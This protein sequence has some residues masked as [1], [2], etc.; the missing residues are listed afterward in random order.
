MSVFTSFHFDFH[1]KHCLVKRKGYQKRRVPKP[2]LILTS[3]P[4]PFLTNLE[5]FSAKYLTH[6]RGLIFFC[7]K[8]NGFQC[9][10]SLRAI[11]IC[12]FVKAM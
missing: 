7:Q 5:R 12:K 11:L 10:L 9:H 1:L 4:L 3:V 6:L 8:F 2:D